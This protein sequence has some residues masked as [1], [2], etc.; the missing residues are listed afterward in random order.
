MSIITWIV[1]AMI[2]AIVAD[3][4]NNCEGFTVDLC[5]SLLG[6]AIGGVVYSHFAAAITP[7]EID[8]YNPLVALF[9]SASALFVYR[10]F[11]TAARHRLG[12]H[13]R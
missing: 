3:Q 1:V 2:A 5:L 12:D 6:A 7:V 10:L 4:V 8:P 13:R 11:A 9:G